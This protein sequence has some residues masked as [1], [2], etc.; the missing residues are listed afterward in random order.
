MPR[1]VRGAVAIGTLPFSLSTKFTEQHA[2]QMNINRYRDNSSQ[3]VCLVVDSRK[4]W[5]LAKR[6]SADDLKLLRE[7]YDNARGGAFYF[8]NPHETL[9]PFAHTNLGSSGRYLVRFANDWTQTNG[10]GRFDTAI[11]LM[12]VTNFGGGGLDD[13][14]GGGII[15]PP[16]PPPPGDVHFLGGGPIDPIN[17]AGSLTGRIGDYYRN[18]GPISYG[19]WMWAFTLTED[20][21]R[22]VADGQMGVYKS[23][24]GVDW[25]RQDVAHAP[26]EALPAYPY[27][28]GSSS[29]VTTL[30]VQ[31]EP[32]PGQTRTT[33]QFVDFDMG[34]GLFGDPYGTTDLR[35]T[36]A[37]AVS[38]APVNDIIHPYVFK[39][40]NGT[41]RVVYQYYYR[42]SFVNHGDGAFPGGSQS[43]IYYQD[44]VPG[45]GWSSRQVFP[46]Q[47]AAWGSHYFLNSATQD[48]DV[49]HAVYMPI[50][51]L[52]NTPP[53]LDQASYVRINAD[54]S[55][56]SPQGIGGV[57]GPNG[58]TFFSLN[59]GI[60][61][62]NRLLIPVVKQSSLPAS[63]GVLVGTPK[64]N[65][66][67]SYVEIA[68]PAAGNISGMQM[69]HMDSRDIFA[70]FQSNPATN[71]NSQILVSVSTNGGTTWTTPGMALDLD[72]TPATPVAHQDTVDINSISLGTNLNG[73]LGLM[74]T[75]WIAYYAPVSP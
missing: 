1:N 27:W 25:I 63:V 73:G 33:V 37:G 72:A 44:Y 66:T 54:G 47:A 70:F 56:T 74:Y 61:S 36:P 67:F 40:S 17:L 7:F 23:Q 6:L 11:E 57:L 41:M 53:A 28:D 22:G 32:V 49:I 59:T 51:G 30:A 16:P 5:S 35:V 8:Y 68:Q 13:T 45:T 24:D 75:S 3:R 10:M 60:I 71:H 52:E 55:F 18:Y 20:D 43:Q 29:I 58:G 69:Y 48:G 2:V 12:E 9:P 50:P 14:G 19:G 39:L 31:F 26:V 34:T 4:S 21:S 62:G 42:D 15:T 65:P 38:G 46:S 64:S